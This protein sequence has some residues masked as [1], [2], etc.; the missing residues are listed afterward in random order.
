MRRLGATGTVGRGRATAAAVLLAV[1]LAAWLTGAARGQEAP[2]GIDV[3][4]WQGA[5]DW[6]Q[7]G[8][9]G[10]G[11]AFAKATE[12]T[13]FTD[14]TYP[15]NRSGVDAIGIRLGAYHFAR[16]AGASDAAVVAS[17]IAQAER[18]LAFAQ[19]RAGDLLPVL[20]LEQT[21][22]L[23]ST[24]LIAWTQAWL[25]HVVARL[26][27]RP[28]IYASPNFWK[29]ALSDTP[30]FAAAAHRLWIAHWTRSVLPILPG[31]GWGGLGWTFWQWTNCTQVPGIVRCVD[32]DRY[33]GTDL[34]VTAL[35]AFP[36]APPIA[37][38]PPTVVGT[39]E[40]GR[41]LVAVP[42][43]WDGGKP[44]SFTYQWQRCDAAGGA[45]AP[46]PEADEV[47][48]KPTA[49]DV[50]HALLVSVTAQTSA[51]TAVAASP[52]TL[53]VASSGASPASAPK[54][55]SL[56]TIEGL[57][58]A[59]ET[60]SGLVGTWSGAPTAFTYQ[61]RRCAAD[62]SA[63]V[64]IPD[65]G[66]TGYAIS[67]GDIGATVSLVVTA[68]GR[69]GSRSATA[70][71]SPVVAAAPVP[72]PAVGSAAAAPGQ[73]GAVATAGGTATASW[74]PGAVPAQATVSLADSASRLALPG[75]TIAVGIDA[76]T[77]LAWPLDVRYASAPPD[78]VPA[79]LPGRG[80]WQAVAQ[81]PSALLEP[82]QDAGAY[83]DT[84]G[85]LHVLMRRPG[86]LALFAPGKWGDPRLVSSARPSLTLTNALVATTRRDGTVLLLARLT[87][88]S[89]AHL[90][91]S[92]VTP[93]GR[94]ALL[95]QEGSRLGGW[96]RGRSTK[97]LQTLALRPG[98]LPIRVRAPAGQLRGKGSFALRIAAIDPYGRRAQLVV[99]FS[100][101][102]ASAPG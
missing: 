53:A 29:T 24:R 56:P 28:I 17:A 62:G 32:G 20:D 5:I 9:A 95:L 13:T 76:A 60:L 98:A 38:A 42:G 67:P 27:S 48:Y 22:N 36:S 97:T 81:L 23:S 68:T 96:V 12:G 78:A 2:R 51:G 21:G 100:P 33:N 46:I 37:V 99:P 35:P 89:Q 74:Q 50:G 75:T 55:I 8:A 11:F 88:D 70:I 39:P 7:V 80:V 93:S 10:Y 49:A 64:A 45:C 44:V 47:T 73:A 40:I 6:L 69:G 59:G 3:S 52:P 79:F 72:E 102:R 87:L 14:A 91:A 34:A 58:Q 25:D 43:G 26:G 63:C 92:V 90:Y 77:P 19:P 82:G 18:F 61:W 86:R 57:A 30:V 4:N 85:A 54:P 15:L 41:L 31:A 84:S 65:A 1:V 101:S 16:P 71:S 94:K 66:G 83:R